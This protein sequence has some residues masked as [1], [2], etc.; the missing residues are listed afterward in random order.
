[1]LD[2]ILVEKIF[3]TSAGPGMHLLHCTRPVLRVFLCRNEM[4]K[5]TPK[6]NFGPIGR[7]FGEKK[8][9]QLLWARECIYCT[10]PDPFYTSFRAETKW[11]KTHPNNILDVKTNL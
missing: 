9:L 7:D 4:L 6:H 2:T 10:A 8:F 3:T 11:L 1:M 5:N